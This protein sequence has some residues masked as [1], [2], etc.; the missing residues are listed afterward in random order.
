MFEI[1]IALPSNPPCGKLNDNDLD[2]SFEPRCTP[3]LPNSHPRGYPTIHLSKSIFK[4]RPARSLKPTVRFSINSASNFRYRRRVS[5]ATTLVVP[6]EAESYRRFSPCQLPVVRFFFDLNNRVVDP[7]PTPFRCHW[8]NSVQ[9]PHR[10][11]CPAQQYGRNLQQVRL[12]LVILKNRCKMQQAGPIVMPL[13]FHH[14]S[15]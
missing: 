9:P 12:A 4:N 13:R 8:I 6:S 7:R 2:L 10:P 5:L 15:R 3:A 14:H 11:A 1:F